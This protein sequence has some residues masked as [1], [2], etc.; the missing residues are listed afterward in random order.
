MENQVHEE[1]RIGSFWSN[2]FKP[3]AEKNELESVLTSMPPFKNLSSKFIRSLM[4]LIHNRL[5]A[6][7]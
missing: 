3:P 6:A 5:Y 2:L 4:D 7:N 1:I